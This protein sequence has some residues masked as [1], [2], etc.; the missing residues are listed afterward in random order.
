MGK[1]RRENRF[2]SKSMFESLPL[3][4][5]LSTDQSL[6]TGLPSTKLGT[7]IENRVNNFLKKKDAGAGEVTIRVVSSVDKMVEVKPGMKAR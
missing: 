1:K 4:F 3:S 7:Y 6:F 2:A 5:P